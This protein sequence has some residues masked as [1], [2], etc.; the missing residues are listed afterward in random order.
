MTEDELAE[1]EERW[2]KASS[3][4]WIWEVNPKYHTVSLRSRGGLVVMDLVRWGM[5]SAAP[6]FLDENH[7]LHRVDKLMEPIPGREHHSHWAQQVNHPDAVAIAAAPEDV[8]D[9]IAEVRRLKTENRAMQS[10][11]DIAEGRVD[12]MKNL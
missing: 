6:R 11:L 4:A 2:S 12:G 5:G 1:I 9:L 3:G 7:L 10:R 8:R